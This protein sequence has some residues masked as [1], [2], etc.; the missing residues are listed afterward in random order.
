M[1]FHLCSWV[2][3]PEWIVFCDEFIPAAHLPSYNTLSHQIIL[4]IAADFQAHACAH[5]KGHYGTL[6]GDGWTGVNNHHH[7]VYMVAVN[8]KVPLPSVQIC[9]RYVDNIVTMCCLRCPSGHL[10]DY[11]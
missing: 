6:Q 7:L 11:T 2:D 10:L 1:T 9:V 3:N 8:G 4:N 5:S